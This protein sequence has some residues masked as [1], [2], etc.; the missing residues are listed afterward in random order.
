MTGPPRGTLDSIWIKPA[1]S[2]P[3]APVAQAMVADWGGGTYGEALD[4]GEIAVG[5]AIRWIE[6]TGRSA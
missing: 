2:A 3:M 6:E 4:D 5:D 1:C